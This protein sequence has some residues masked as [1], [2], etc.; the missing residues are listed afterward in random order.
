[1]KQVNDGRSKRKVRITAA[2][3]LAFTFSLL[4]FTAFAGQ[5]DQRRGGG[6]AVGGASCVWSVVVVDQVE[7]WNAQKAFGYGALG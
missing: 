7:V 1:M 5:I 6:V 3:P 2:S 4:P